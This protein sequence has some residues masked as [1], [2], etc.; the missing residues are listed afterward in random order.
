MSNVHRPLFWPTREGGAKAQRSSSR[1][2]ICI[3]GSEVKS[4]NA[5]QGSCQEVSLFKPLARCP[6]HGI[7]NNVIWNKKSKSR[8][9]E[10]LKGPRDSGPDL[11]DYKT[12]FFDTNIGYKS[13]F[14]RS[15]R[16]RITFLG[17]PRTQ[18]THF[19][20]V[21]ARSKINCLGGPRA[22]KSLFGRSARPNIDPKKYTILE[23]FY[24]NQKQ[25]A[26]SFQMM[27]YISRLTNLQKAIKENP[28]AII[29]VERSVFTDRY[30]FASM[31]HD[32]EKINEIEYQVY[33]K[34]F[35]HF[36]SELPQM[37]IIYVHTFP[38]VCYSRVKKRGVCKFIY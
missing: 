10:F 34:W 36:I 22:Q 21:R 29:I 18:K 14:L 11:G 3:S 30:V 12:L 5:L 20:E 28:E 23:R 7:R 16:S 15:T 24:G 26:F 17:G 19:W 38:S 4:L 37:S 1:S 31:L 9:A 2:I 35:D 13:L 25:Y 32:E 6:S 27:A 8:V 33:L